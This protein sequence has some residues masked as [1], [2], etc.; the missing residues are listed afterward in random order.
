MNQTKFTPKE[1]LMLLSELREGLTEDEDANLL[2]SLIRGLDEE[3]E[4][5]VKDELEYIRK[6]KENLKSNKP[7]V[8]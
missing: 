4:Q 6:F 2:G 3:H 5:I 8:V 1:E 7:Y